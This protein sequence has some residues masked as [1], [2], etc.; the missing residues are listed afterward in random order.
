MKKITSFL[1]CLCMILSMALSAGAAENAKPVYLALGDDIVTDEGDGNFT[2]IIGDTMGYEVVNHGV[3]GQTLS[4]LLAQ[5]ESHEI[6]SDIARADVITLTCGF[7]DI[8]N[9]F[10]RE[11]AETYNRLNEPDI[12]EAEVRTILES[13]GDPRVMKVGAAAMTVFIGNE[14]DGV[15]PYMETEEFQVEVQGFMDTASMIRDILLATNPDAEIIITNLYN[16][17]RNFTGL[18]ATLA[19][20]F[21]NALISLNGA[22]AGLGYTVADEYT[23][24]VNATEDLCNSSSSPVSMDFT[25]NAAG[26]KVFANVILKVLPGY[27]PFQDVAQTDYFYAPVLWAVEN[28]ITAGLNAT[29]FGPGQN[30]TRAQVV[31]FLGRAAGQPE[32]PS[33]ENPFEDVTPA[34]YFYK[35]V[36]WAVEN[37]ITAGMSKTSFG[38]NATCTRGQVVT[39]LWR[40]AGK[41]EAAN[42][43]NDFV[44]VSAAD[45]FYA[46]V[47][48]AVENKITAGMGA[49]QFAPGNSCTRGQVVTFLYRANAQ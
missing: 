7:N 19:V 45:Y 1:L 29:T 48:W 12:T 41:P 16:P 26:H 36:L 8:L 49:G 22:L 23:A 38:P 27:N 42:A 31:T 18:F 15:L 44:D 10:F 6:E 24:F 2:Q 14:L 43:Q 33:T 40:A 11:T 39:F 20:G 17:Y 21:D 13:D 46:P 25:P 47:L 28:G 30:C 9:M 4:S 32:P 3:D 34:D 37:N 35:P 5:L